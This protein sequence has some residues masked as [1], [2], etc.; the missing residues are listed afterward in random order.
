MISIYVPVVAVVVK[1]AEE[2]LKDHK[3]PFLVMFVTFGRVVIWDSENDE[4]Y[5]QGIYSHTE[6]SDLLVAFGYTFMYGYSAFLHLL[7]SNYPE[8]DY[9]DRIDYPV[10]VYGLSGYT[11]SPIPDDELVYGG[12]HEY[13]GIVYPPI[14]I[15]TYNNFSQSFSH[16]VVGTTL[17]GTAQSSGTMNSTYYPSPPATREYYDAWVPSA[18]GSVHLKLY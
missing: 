1:P 2:V 3:K 5:K 6:V 7:I 8:I 12:I 14:P 16:S 10:L 9:W 17:V 4:A 18:H 15:P 11:L 13:G